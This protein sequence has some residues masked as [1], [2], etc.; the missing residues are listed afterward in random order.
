MTTYYVETLNRSCTH[1]CT[2]IDHYILALNTKNDDDDDDDD[3]N[4][5]CYNNTKEK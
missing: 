2:S 3:D 4:N 1:N 5:N